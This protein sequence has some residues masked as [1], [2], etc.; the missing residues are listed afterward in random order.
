MKKILIIDDDPYIRNFYK[1]FLEENGFVVIEAE[2]GLEGMKI[3]REES[4]NL[5]LL[6]INMPEKSGLDILKE[7]K[8]KNEKIPVFLLTAHE[9]YKRNF[10]SLYA[11]EYFVKN[12]NPEI[13]L[14]R[15]NKYFEI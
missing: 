9:D 1:E 6:D 12:K 7:I 2:N 3:F 11:D 15:I 13:I 10:S 5:I 8:K 4:P 14:K